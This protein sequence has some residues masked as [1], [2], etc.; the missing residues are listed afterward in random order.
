MSP[1]AS[2]V[3]SKSFAALNG[4]H[5]ARAK[6]ALSICSE[7]KH[8]QFL[9]RD[10][11]P[12]IEPGEFQVFVGSSSVSGLQSTFE[13]VNAYSKTV[14][15]AAAKDAGP[16]EPP[17]A[18]PVPEAAVSPQD[19]AFLED[20]ERRSFQY[21]WDHTNPTNGLTLDR[22]G[23]DGKPK[24]K[25]HDALQYRQHRRLRL[26]A[27]RLLHRRRPRLDAACGGA[28]KGRRNT[29]DFFANR[30]I[31]KNGWFYHWMDYDSGERRWN[32]EIS[33]ID[34]A[35]LL[36]GVLTVKNCFGDDK[37]IARLADRIYARVD[38][39]WMLN[40]DPIFSHTD[41]GPNPAGYRTD[42][43]ITASR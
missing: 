43:T 10:I 38:F 22:S 27:K 32:S 31:H 28:S 12:V 29:L 24:P 39:N 30:A 16:I 5:W 25:T 18:A 23:T 2:R 15:A 36:G 33:S 40:G 7:P 11:K 34:T 17:P 13:V 3:L 9:G 26:C 37:E 20:V 21:F 42:G 41:G 6:N 14:P 4:S 35:L 8:L 19:D 1:Q